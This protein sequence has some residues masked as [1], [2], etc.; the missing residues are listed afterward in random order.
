ME[1]TMVFIFGTL[2][3]L[4]LWVAFFLII[5][6]LVLWYWKVDRAVNALEG[7]YELQ[8]L[9]NAKEIQTKRITLINKSTQKLVEMSIGDYLKKDN[10]HNYKIS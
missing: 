3:T 2:L 5:R 10:K 8:L 1:E 9:L 7:L 4:V 6:K